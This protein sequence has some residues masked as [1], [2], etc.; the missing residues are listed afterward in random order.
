LNSNTTGFPAANNQTL[1][2]ILSSYWISFTI[3]HDP[4]PYRSP[5]APFWPSYRGAGSSY[6]DSLQALAVT[7]TTVSPIPDPDVGPK[8][9]FFSSRGYVVRN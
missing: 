1:A 2:E 8:C 6:N 3:A 9:D 5:N 7:Y 4:N